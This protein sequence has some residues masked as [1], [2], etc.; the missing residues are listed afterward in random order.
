RVAIWLP[1]SIDL[2]VSVLA[3]LRVGALPLL[4]DPS[5][6]PQRQ[7][8]LLELARADL[9]I[10]R[11]GNHP[12]A[13]AGL[14]SLDPA[15]AGTIETGN[16]HSIESQSLATDRTQA[17]AAGAF[18]AFTSGSTGA[19]RGVVCTD[20][21]LLNRLIWFEESFPARAD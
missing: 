1:R 6:P 12:A 3:C 4:L 8:R 7:A 13:A 17:R 14:P 21:A 5:H 19:P 2:A 15:P 16:R 11:P 18:I 10:A 9:L 20:R